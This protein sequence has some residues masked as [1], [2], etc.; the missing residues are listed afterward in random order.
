M[1]LVCE[2]SVINGAY[3]VLFRRNVSKKSTSVS[4]ALILAK[5]GGF[6]K[7]QKN[8][9]PQIVWQLFLNC[10]HNFCNHMSGMK[11]INLLGCSC[12]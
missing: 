8:I 1:K 10:F 5:L 4:N 3:P 2:G 7:L 11:R 9:A 12:V 6:V